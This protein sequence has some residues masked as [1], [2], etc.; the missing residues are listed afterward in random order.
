MLNKNDFFTQDLRCSESF[1]NGY[2]Q[3]M[4]GLTPKKY[5]IIPLND[6][7]TASIHIANL[8]LNLFNKVYGDIIQKIE[9]AKKQH[10]NHDTLNQ[11]LKQLKQLKSDLS[12]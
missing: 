4:A 7:N 12:S 1:Q 11:L 5:T 8:K 9:Q 3:I 10:N 6:K 2:M